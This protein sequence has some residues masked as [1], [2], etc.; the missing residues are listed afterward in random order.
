MS[1]SGIVFPTETEFE[2]CQVCHREDC[3]GRKAP[4]DETVWQAVCGD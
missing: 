2:S 4:F 3:P 1:V